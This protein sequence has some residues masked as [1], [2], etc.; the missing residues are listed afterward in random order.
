MLNFILE[1][2]SAV[3]DQFSSKANPLYTL[4][5]VLLSFT[6]LLLCIIELVYKGRKERVA[7]SQMCNGNKVPWLY[8]DKSWFN[9]KDR[10]G[11]LCAMVQPIVATINYALV[12]RHSGQFQ[13]SVLPIVFALV[14]SC[15][16]ICNCPNKKDSEVIVG[17]EEK[18]VIQDNKI[19]HPNLRWTVRK[20]SLLKTITMKETD[21]VVLWEKT[22]DE[23][24]YVY[25]A[26]LLKGIVSPITRMNR[27]KMEG[28]AST[29][30][31]EWER[32]WD[33][34]KKVED[35]LSELL[36]NMLQSLAKLRK[37]AR[38]L[39]YIGI[40]APN[41]TLEKLLESS[42]IIDDRYWVEQ[43]EKYMDE[44]EKMLKSLNE[45]KKT[46]ELKNL[47]AFKGYENFSQG[48]VLYHTKE[49]MYLLIQRELNKLKKLSAIN[50]A[51]W[52]SLAEEDKK[53]SSAKGKT[54]WVAEQP[55]LDE[56]KE[57]ISAIEDTNRFLRG[58]EPLDELKKRIS[59]KKRHILGCTGKI[60]E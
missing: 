32:Q 9:F 46:M 21:W 26:L 5:L 14:L 54:C 7:W 35:T 39:R 58:E 41:I 57:K 36:V 34:P 50:D 29:E 11:F 43:V 45:F 6:A 38:V 53:K 4:I 33:E 19:A 8:P 27:L 55:N 16:K 23:L 28:V 30:H 59:A 31:L 51:Y 56:L 48:N 12:L 44:L 1:F 42:V 18:S 13:I 37:T 15:S 40:G 24:V 22:V 20:V 47:G 3:L 17:Q 60:F 2:P 10:V 25:E 49:V 52:F